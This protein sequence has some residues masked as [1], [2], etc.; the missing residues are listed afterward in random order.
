M[1]SRLN[2]RPANSHHVTH[3]A[4]TT[5]SEQVV[6]RVGKSPSQ[7]HDAPY[8]YYYGDADYTYGQCMYATFI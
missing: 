7:L 8:S 1:T 4:M 5:G 6:A 3:V 2:K